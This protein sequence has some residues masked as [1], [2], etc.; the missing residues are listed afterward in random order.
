LRAKW[1]H[2]D[3][4]LTKKPSLQEGERRRTP[5]GE[6][7]QHEEAFGLVFYKE[8]CSLFLII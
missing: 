4:A 1:H 5:P 3:L 2:V 8:S 6:R 7:A